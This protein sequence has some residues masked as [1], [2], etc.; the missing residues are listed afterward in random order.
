MKSRLRLIPPKQRFALRSGRWM[1]PIILAAGL[2]MTTPSSPSPPPHPHQRLPSVSQRNPSG[3][4]E[5]ALTN[6]RRLASL[7]PPATTSNTQIARGAAPLT[8]TYSLVSSGEKQRPFGLGTSPVA[9][10]TFPVL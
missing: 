5:P 1:R 10:V 3:T 9:T 6:R 4:P 7:V 8:T 2:K